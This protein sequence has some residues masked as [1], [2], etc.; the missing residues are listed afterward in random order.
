DSLR[1]YFEPRFGKDLSNVRLHTD[2]RAAESAKRLKA[3]AFTQGPDIYFASGRYQPQSDSGR[4]LLAH[5]ITHT[6][7]QSGGG[8]AP[9]A[10]QAQGSGPLVS[11][12]AQGSVQRD[13]DGSPAAAPHQAPTGGTDH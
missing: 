1:G 13:G 9:A 5:E 6:L 4:H 10:P 12:G 7:Q 11:R 8:A 3:Q 2:S